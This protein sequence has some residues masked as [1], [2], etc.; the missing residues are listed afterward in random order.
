MPSPILEV[1]HLSHYFDKGK[2][3]AL[4]DVNFSI[5]KGEV[6]GLVG[7]SGSGK[8]TTGRCIIKLLKISDGEIFFKGERISAG[9][10]SLEKQLREAK[11]VGD[12]G[13]IAELKK[14]IDARK[15]DTKNCDKIWLEKNSAASAK[16]SASENSSASA[17][18]KAST[19]LSTKIQMIFQDPVASL[20]PRM[21][22]REIVAEGL[23]IGGE[24]DEKIITQKVAEVLRTVGLRPE[25]A[26]R[27]PH[28][29][30][31]GQ[32]QRIGIARVLVVEPE[33]IIADEPVS[34]LD[35]SIR[36]QIINLLDDI[37]KKMGVTIL[38]VAHD[39]SVVKY[40]CDRIAVMYKGK[41]VETNTSDELFKNPQHE[42]TKKL[43]SS[44]PLPDPSQAKLR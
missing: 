32:R 26:D 19:R 22:V 10:F 35:V 11:K 6:F 37:R 21:T 12:A 39:L 14:E 27:Y 20:D 3:L 9:T 17:G 16:A 41:I 18:A 30:S 44:I 25:H 34:A 33:L 7:E 5:N 23:R 29:F 36:A 40:F 1:K 28:E 13:K 38:F 4:D 8:T 31:G 2:F 24:R 43:L 15:N 42:Y